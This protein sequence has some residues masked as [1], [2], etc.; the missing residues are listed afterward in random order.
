[1]YGK[2]PSQEC[3][4]NFLGSFIKMYLNFFKNSGHPVL[5]LLGFGRSLAIKCVSMNNQQCMVGPRLID[6]NPD[7][8]HYYSFLVNIEVCNRNYNTVQ[9][10]FGRICVSNEMEDLYLKVFDTIKQINE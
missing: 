10:A 8:L 1:M 9:D 2:F 4:S 7:E 6:L 5:V 3:I